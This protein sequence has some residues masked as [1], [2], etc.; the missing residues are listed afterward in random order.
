MSGTSFHATAVAREAERSIRSM[1]MQRRAAAKFMDEPWT[2]HA[3]RQLIDQSSLKNPVKNT[4]RGMVDR[5]GGRHTTVDRSTLCLV[6]G[7][8][9]EAT[10]TAHWHRAREAGLL[11]SKQRWNSTSVHMGTTA[12]RLACLDV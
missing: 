12:G 11:V 10:I 4:L 3:Y 6:T 7:V 8:R 5:A 2:V 1:Y 9:R